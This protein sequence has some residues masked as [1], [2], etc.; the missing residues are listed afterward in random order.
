MTE[1]QY[2]LTQKF[3]RRGLG[4]LWSKRSELDPGQVAIIDSIWKNKK[5]GSLEGLQTITY[6]L[7]NK[8]P[9]KLGY[10]RFYGSKG[11]LETLEK[12]C[13]GT[14][15]KDYY[16]DID[17][18]NCHPVL[19]VQY[20]KETYN[21]ELPELTYYV[22]HRD[23]VLK[24]ISENREEAK[25]EF[26]R[27][28]YGGRNKFPSTEKLAKEIRAFSVFLA[29]QPE[30]TELYEECKK[31]DNIYGS[32]LSYVL[33]TEEV[34]CMLAMKK[35]L[36]KQK[37]VVGVLCY[38]GLMI[39]KSENYK[40]D[41]AIIVGLE[42][43]IKKETKYEVKV[44]EK[45]MVSFDLPNEEEELVPG[46]TKKAYEEMKAKFEENHFYYYPMD[47]CAEITKNGIV[48]YNTLHAKTKFNKEY[49]FMRSERFGDYVEFF[50]LWL[51]DQSRRFVRSIS[52]L[53][54][55]DL[56]VYTQPIDFEYNIHRRLRI[57]EC[58][59]CLMNS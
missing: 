39:E 7:S 5:K 52:Y 32:L 51:K 34:K 3:S 53:D 11:S 12:E 49:I 17:I 18:V 15:C 22:N 4:Y 31:N 9:G 43:A 10:G 37:I 40:L 44:V 29:N 6:K 8:K 58:W 2:V 48:F 59:N 26:I 47:T 1:V 38:D 23:A 41:D 30:H 46:V 27:L 36:E 35:Y 50:P 28:L 19:L 16:Y 42:D 54:S 55:E 57:K 20:A 14:L 21:K 25:E 33:Q 24:L 56:E 13:R 45:P